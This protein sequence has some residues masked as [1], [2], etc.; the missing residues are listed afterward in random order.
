MFHVFLKERSILPLLDVFSFRYWSSQSGYYC[1]LALLYPYWFLSTFSINYGERSIE[2]SIYDY[3]H[4]CSSFQFCQVLL[5]VFPKLCSYL[6]LWLPY[7]LILLSLQSVP[8]FLVIPLFKKSTLSK[9]V[10]VLQLSH[11]CWC[12]RAMY[13]LPTFHFKLIH[14][15]IFKVHLL[16]QYF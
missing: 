4:L 12:M 6:W 10:L 9:L 14:I 7:I 13:F 15:A 16:E 8:F 3:R 2:V 11:T 1:S 5:L